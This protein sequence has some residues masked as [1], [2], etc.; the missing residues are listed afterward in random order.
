MDE[1]MS[2]KVFVSIDLRGGVL[3]EEHDLA[4]KTIK[5]FKLEPIMAEPPRSPDAVGSEEAN[6]DGVRLSHLYV[7]IIGA[8]TSS[9]SLEEFQEAIRLNIKSYV[10]AKRVTERQLGASKFLE[11]AQ[12]HNFTEFST[13]EEL[14]SQLEEVLELFIAEETLSRIKTGGKSREAVV[15][16]YIEE[17]VKPVLDEIE[18]IESSV[19]EKRF[20]ELPTH[21]W[22]AANVSAFLRTD[23]ELDQLI[24][25][26]YSKVR[27]LN[28]LRNA[29]IKEHENDVVSIMH[30]AFLESAETLNEFNGIE[31]LLGEAYEFFLATRDA[32]SEIAKPLLDQLDVLVR[33]VPSEQ[34][35][36][37]YVSGLWLVNKILQRRMMASLSIVLENPIPRHLGVQYVA[38]FGALYH[39]AK[40]IQGVLQRLYQERSDPAKYD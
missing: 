21:A 9:N 19:T 6:L 29:V 36:V 16:A 32:Y 14:S 26:F 39:E 11:L 30:E 34:K 33:S 40:R 35:R 8:E 24:A 7:A 38:A 10:F 17:Y 22:N 18:R 2:L 23:S 31:R 20:V 12:G 28:D 27:H 3:I 13:L 15:H 37:R 25:E 4:Q 5:E 1:S